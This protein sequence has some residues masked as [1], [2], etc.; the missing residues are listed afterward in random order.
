[1]SNISTPHLDEGM[2]AAQ[3]EAAREQIQA[4]FTNG[5]LAMSFF[6]LG[7]LAALYLAPFAVGQP[8]SYNLAGI[9]T[10]A[11][12]V[13]L[14]L[15]VETLWQK[16]RI[17]SFKDGLFWEENLRA[18]ATTPQSYTSLRETIARGNI[19]FDVSPIGPIRVALF[20]AL[21]AVGLA[22]TI[23]AAYSSPT[24]AKPAT[25]VIAAIA[26]TLLGPLIE[27]LLM[28]PLFRSLSMNMEHYGR[29]ARM[30]RLD[31]TLADLSSKAARPT[32]TILASSASPSPAPSSPPDSSASSDGSTSPDSVSSKILRT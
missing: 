32:N 16:E 3:A 20:G 23:R 7:V 19:G 10:L 27:A 28:R 18:S 31:L 12:A 4:R 9:V 17:T 2:A 26:G 25:F 6:R 1:M 5:L 14:F 24:L 15:L 21:L 29:L 30:R 22:L 11:I 13:A 8:T